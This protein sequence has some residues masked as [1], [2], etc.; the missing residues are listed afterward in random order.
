MPANLETQQWPQDW[1]RSIFIP[2]LKKD[3]AK[4]FSNYSSI[5]LIS[6]ANKVILRIL[7]AR[8]QMYENFQMYKLNLEKAEEPEIKLPTATGS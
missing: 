7:Q 2:V 1:K 8:L 5:A 4:D 6:H 3:N